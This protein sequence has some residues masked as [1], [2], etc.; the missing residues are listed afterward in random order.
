MSQHIIKEIQ[1]LKQQVTQLQEGENWLSGMRPEKDQ[2]TYTPQMKIQDL[3]K[4]VSMLTSRIDK[5]EKLIKDLMNA[6]RSG[7]GGGGVSYPPAA[8]YPGPS[9]VQH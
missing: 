5:H 4:E 7:G 1:I 3:Q 6:L 8:Q 9:P 2:P